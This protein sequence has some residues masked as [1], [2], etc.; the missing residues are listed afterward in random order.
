MSYKIKIRAKKTP[1][2]SLITSLPEDVIFDILARVPRCDYPTLSLV[3]KHFRSLVASSELY[4]RRSLLNCIEHCLYTV[5]FN[6][7]T[8]DYH[9]Y[10]HRRKANDN[11][12]WVLISSIPHMPYGL[13]FV[14]GESRIYVFGGFDQKYTEKWRDACVVDD[15]LYY[16]DGEEDEIRAY[17]PK[18]KCWSVV[19]GLEESLPETTNTWCSK[20]LSYVEGKTYEIWCAKISVERRQGGGIWGQV[21]WCDHVFTSRKL[22]FAKPLAVMV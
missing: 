18:Q 22:S 1:S 15:V 4:A 2:S 3:S 9:L 7:E 5:L 6:Y 16:Y 17:D 21:E 11:R 20:T 19:K 10:I 14:M 13:S 8:K 12:C